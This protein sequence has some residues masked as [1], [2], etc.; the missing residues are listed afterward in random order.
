MKDID[1]EKMQIFISSAKGIKDRFVILSKKL[2]DLLRE[3]YKQY[4]PKKWLFERSIGV[5]F[6]K[7]T[8]Q[9]V[10]LNAVKESG[11]NKSATLT[12][13]KNSFAVHLIEKGV[14]IRYIQQMLGHKHS[15]TTMKY[16]KVSK[17]DLSVIQSPL[18]N[19]DV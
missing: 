10:F 16:L 15:K 5:Q 7:R 8:I 19:L 2:L 3:Y 17:R 6:P 11:I 18:D 13:L 9:K 4:K 12:I 1:S 14:D